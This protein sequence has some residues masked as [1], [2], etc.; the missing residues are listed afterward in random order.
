VELVSYVLLLIIYF[1]ICHLL[2]SEETSSDV[3]FIFEDKLCKTIENNTNLV[4]IHGQR[5]AIT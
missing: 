4:K 5:F 1:H 2:Y 3:S